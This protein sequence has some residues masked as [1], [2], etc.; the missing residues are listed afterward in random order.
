VG[1]PHTIPDEVHALFVAHGRTVR[2]LENRRHGFF[3][4][5]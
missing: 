2:K 1:H 5:A 4:R 3:R